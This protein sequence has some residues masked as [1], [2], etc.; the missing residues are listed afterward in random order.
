MK[1]Q[2]FLFGSILLMISAVLVKIIGALFKIPLTVMLGGT[3]MGYFSCAYGIFL[4]IYAV[5]GN[6]LGAAVSKLTAQSAASNDYRYVNRIK[7]AS[8]LYFGLPSLALSLLIFYF[9]NYFATSILG[10]PQSQ[11]AVAAIAPCIFFASISSILRGHHEGMQNMY[12]TAVSQICE[13]LAKL[14]L[15]LFGALAAMKYYAEISLRLSVNCDK[16]S[17]SAALA[18][19]GVSLSTLFGAISLLIFKSTPNTAKNNKISQAE[20]PLY[21]IAASVMQIMLP[22]ALGALVTN[23]TSLIDLFTV[24]RLLEKCIFENAEYFSTRYDFFKNLSPDE[25]AGFIFGSFSGLALTIF[26]L[27]PAV[28]NMLS[29]S[30]LAASSKA[31]AAGDDKALQAN[32]DKSVSL[33]ALL[34]APSAF[35]IAAMSRQILLLLY[36]SRPDEISASHTAL[37]YLGLSVIFLC[38]SAP[39]FSILQA[40]SNAMAP[41]KIMLIGVFAKLVGNLVFLKFKQTALYGAAIS[42]LLCYI[43]I[44]AMSSTALKRKC[45]ISIN[46]KQNVFPFVLS[47][48]VCAFGA[49]LSNRLYIMFLPE[50]IATC[51]AIFTAAIIY[52]AMLYFVDKRIHHLNLR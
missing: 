42:T 19:S 43:L 31:F 27:V 24:N 37:S 12:P 23:L 32:L 52:L 40:T 39:I 46:I 5:L 1:K 22:I 20:A 9:S 38:L 49:F 29:K 10:S 17:L 44:F 26:N 16:Q 18:I 50:K 15:G 14:G 35:G 7:Y 45:K 36:S 11:L 21:K 8:L 47:G 30:V 25:S 4:P 2:S 6:G 3:A 51:S 34:A 48:A 13:A 33:T 41:V 28:T